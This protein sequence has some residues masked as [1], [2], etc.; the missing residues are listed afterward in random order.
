M[1]HRTGR[2]PA[3]R[4][5]FEPVL[6]SG[7][8]HETT[9]RVSRGGRAM[10]GNLNAITTVFTEFYYW[11]TIPL[12]FFIHIGFCMYEVGASRRRNHM[13]TLMKNTMLIPLVTIHVLLL[14]LVALLGHAERALDYGRSRSC[15]G[16][17][18][19]ALV[20][21]HGAE[22]RRPDYRRVLGGLPAVLV[23]GGLHRVRFGDR[24][25]Q[26]R[27]L[28]DSRRRDRVGRLDYRRRLGLALRRLDGPASGLPRRLRLRRDP[29]DRRR[30]RAR[31]PGGAGPAAR[32]VRRG[33]HAAGHQSA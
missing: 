17:G 6:P 9:A 5:W 1:L 18:Q 32:Q 25:D 28:L 4:N 31:H 27:R 21:D 2:S 22:R 7:R 12:M 23:D 10:E 26:F 33:R 13:H 11:A 14:R 19:H 24:A 3:A 16:S 30:V 29:R 15:G 8:C 20:R